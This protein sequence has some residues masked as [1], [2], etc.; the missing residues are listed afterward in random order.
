MLLISTASLAATSKNTPGRRS[1]LKWLLHNHASCPNWPV[2]RGG[3]LAPQFAGVVGRHPPSPAA[4]GSASSTSHHAGRPGG[5]G[6]PVNGDAG[7]PATAAGVPSGRAAAAAAAAVA[8]AMGVA[9]AAGTAAAGTEAPGATARMRT[10]GREVGKRVASPTS[11]P[12]VVTDRAAMR[13]TRP[14]RRD[15]ASIGATVGP[16]QAGATG[17]GEGAQ[18]GDATRQ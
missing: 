2:K 9:V 8:V 4:R 18:G 17:G 14:S 3:A 1:A 15:R 7:A 16:R 6:K 13:A 10:A 12:P 11:A 5:S